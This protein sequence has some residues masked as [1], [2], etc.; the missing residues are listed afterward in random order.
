MDRRGV[1]ESPA[2]AGKDADIGFLAVVEVVQLPCTNAN[3]C[4]LELLI[5]L[6]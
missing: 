2:F 4:F 3:D 1:I 6:T 5:S